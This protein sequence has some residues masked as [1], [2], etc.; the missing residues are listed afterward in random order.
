MSYKSIDAFKTEID[1]LSLDIENLNESAKLQ[2]IKHLEETIKIM[3]LGSSLNFGIPPAKKIKLEE[4]NTLLEKHTQTDFEEML[5]KEG[6]DKYE[7]I[8]KIGEKFVKS[9]YNGNIPKCESCGRTFK[10]LGALDIHAKVHEKEGDKM[11]KSINL[12]NE[13]QCQTCGMKFP[14]I[15]DMEKHSNDEENCLIYMNSLLQDGRSSENFASVTQN[16]YIA[17]ESYL[18]SPTSGTDSNQDTFKC[19]S[20]T[21]EFSSKRSL[22]RHRILHTDKFEC[23]TCQHRFMYRKDLE[24]HNR[25]SDS[26]KRFLKECIKVEV[27]EEAQDILEEGNTKENLMKSNKNSIHTLVSSSVKSELKEESIRINDEAISIDSPAIKE[28]DNMNSFS[29]TKCEKSFPRRRYLLHH[30]IIH[31]DKYACPTCNHRFSAKRELDNH[32][33]NLYN[34]QKFL[35]DTESSVPEQTFNCRE[36]DSVLTSNNSFEM[37]MKKHEEEYDQEEAEELFKCEQCYKNFANSLSFS[38]HMETHVVESRNRTSI[39]DL[40]LDTTR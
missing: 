34:C 3:K 36:C 6:N 28:P 23:K 17:S 40:I 11:K 32:S 12:N 39:P 13:H 8:P 19:D 18:K 37:H 1:I 15:T 29:C 33:K 30:S 38:S 5:L 9:L 10:T 4:S 25:N 26:C 16:G 31:T 20:C 27:K 2:V 24:V 22:H 14:D 7:H 35:K 21:K